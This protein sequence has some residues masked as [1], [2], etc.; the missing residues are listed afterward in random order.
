MKKFVLFASLFLT[1]CGSTEPARE[2]SRADMPPVSGMKY[3]DFK[4]HD[5]NKGGSSIEAQKRFIKL[6]RDNNGVLS[7]NEMSGY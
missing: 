7:Q 3:Q 5:W 2:V 1:A 4:N 6:D